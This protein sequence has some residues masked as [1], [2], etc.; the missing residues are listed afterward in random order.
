MISAAAWVD[1]TDKR[2]VV[3]FGQLATKVDG[4]DYGSDN[5]PHVW[6]GPEVCCHGQD[7]RPLW[8]ATGPGTPTSVPHIWIYDPNDFALVAQG[9]KPYHGLTPKA[10]FPISAVS[11]AFPRNVGW[12]YWG[13][14]HFNATSRLLFVATNSDDTV[15]N[16]FEPRPVIRVFHI[17]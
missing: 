13:G 3:F 12:Y 17:R 4:F 14:A 15:S 2:G 10:V 11:S 9:K 6:Y 8:M 7:G 1:L 5:V 16:P